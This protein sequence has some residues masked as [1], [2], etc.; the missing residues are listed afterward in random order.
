M[1]TVL[2]YNTAI[3]Q[4]PL[5]NPKVIFKILWWYLL[6]QQYSITVRVKQNLVKQCLA[7]GNCNN[8]ERWQDCGTSQVYPIILVTS[9]FYYSSVSLHPELI[10][11]AVIITELGSVLACLPR[12]DNSGWTVFLTYFN[13]IKEKTACL[14]PSSELWLIWL[15]IIYVEDISDHV[16]VMC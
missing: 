14:C 2:D 4:K 9:A 16:H 1:L 15:I 3:D 5:K 8:S 7:C 6:I 10:A 13:W 12:V 11:S